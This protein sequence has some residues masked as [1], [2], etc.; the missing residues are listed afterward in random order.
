[1]FMHLCLNFLQVNNWPMIHENEK[2]SAMR[3][4]LYFKMKIYCDFVMV[5]SS[6]NSF[7]CKP[8]SCEN[9]VNELHVSWLHT[10]EISVCLVEIKK[11][12]E[13][14]G[15][16]PKLLVIRIFHPKFWKFWYT[17]GP[18]FFVHVWHQ[19]SSRVRNNRIFRH[20][21]TQEE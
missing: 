21:I 5:H 10:I 11:R 18:S 4:K 8:A 17:T 9:D 13:I 12:G 7:N 20:A 19:V 15:C 6:T 2:R 1:M 3:L 16:Y 14:Q